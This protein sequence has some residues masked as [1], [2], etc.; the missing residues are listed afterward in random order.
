MAN[1]KPHILLDEAFRE[2]Q[3]HAMAFA[4]P[5]YDSRYPKPIHPV[6]FRNNYFFEFYRVHSIYNLQ[7]L[8]LPYTIQTRF[9]KEVFPAEK[10]DSIGA[11]HLKLSIKIVQ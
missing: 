8:I 10:S 9:G 6:L 2:I 11:E 7:I 3:L 4:Q 1:L 5:C